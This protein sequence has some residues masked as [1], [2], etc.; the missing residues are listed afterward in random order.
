MFVAVVVSF[1]F[2]FFMIRRPPRS[3]RTDTLFP[4]TTLFR[5]AVRRQLQHE[6]DR[7]GAAGPWA[8]HRQLLRIQPAAL[9]ARGDVPDIV[10]RRNSARAVRPDRSGI[11]TRRGVSARIFVD[12][13]RALLARRLIP[14][15]VV[16]H[17][18]S[19]PLLGRLVH[20]T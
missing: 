4:Y 18:E 2:F 10:A 8:R 6:R 13:L 15:A 19:D 20:R 7:Q 5:S 16:V 17:V 3:T 1:C 11:G 12:A 9:P 14:F